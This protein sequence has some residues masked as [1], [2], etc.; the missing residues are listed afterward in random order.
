VLF[1][2]V[3]IGTLETLI[4]EIKQ[5]IIIFYGNDSESSITNRK[6]GLLLDN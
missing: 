4:V 5:A 1:Q 2:T 6:K 3:V